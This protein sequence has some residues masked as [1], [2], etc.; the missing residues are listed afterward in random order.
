[1]L[2]PLCLLWV[3]S[4]S[5]IEQWGLCQAPGSYRTLWRE[6]RS[7]MDPGRSHYHQRGTAS[8]KRRRKSLDNTGST[9]KA[10]VAAGSPP[11][12]SSTEHLPTLV[13]D[14]PCPCRGVSSHPQLHGDGDKGQTDTASQGEC[15]PV[16]C[17]QYFTG[18]LER[19][20]NSPFGKVTSAVR[21]REGQ[22]REVPLPLAPTAPGHQGGKGKAPNHLPVHWRKH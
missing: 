21:Q 1:M 19:R 12:L 17:L 4:F 2:S 15:K 8:R 10:M 22:G 3:M 9:G 7:P 16:L 6:V 20:T 11:S 5:L 13:W 14:G 18:C